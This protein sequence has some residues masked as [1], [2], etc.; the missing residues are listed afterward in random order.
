MAGTSGGLALPDKGAAN[1]DARILIQLPSFEG[2]DAQLATVP[3]DNGANAL[4]YFRRSS[5]TAPRQQQSEGP[6]RA[7]DAL[8]Q[9]GSFRI[10]ALR[11]SH[12]V[13]L[14]C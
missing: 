11:A 9:R 3:R 12:N 10:P 8:V 4:D 13:Q 1:G 5:P 14:P 7:R 2:G 6:A